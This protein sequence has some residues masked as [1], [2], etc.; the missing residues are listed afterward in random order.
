MVELLL[1]SSLVVGLM[2]AV[3]RRSG[4]ISL[5]SVGSV[6]SPARPLAAIHSFALPQPAAPL[7]TGNR[8]VSEDLPCPWCGAATIETDVSCPW[9]GQ[10]F[11]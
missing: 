6:R 11:G 10:Q 4:R 3:G 2:F 9:C 7:G 1:A 8:V 5:R